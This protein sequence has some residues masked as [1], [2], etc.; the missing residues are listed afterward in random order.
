MP[1]DTITDA[2]TIEHT[3]DILAPA[4]AV[5][6]AWADV[7]RWREWDPDTRSARLAG[8]V[9]AGTRGWLRPRRGLPVRLQVVEA[10][11]PRRL[12]V[13]CPVLG[14]RL[15]FVHELEELAPGRLRVRHRASFHGWLARWLD[16][17]VGEDLR[18]GLP[19]TMAGLKRHVEAA[20]GAP[21]RALPQRP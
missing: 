12:V 8:P 20:G 10:Q 14:S 19:A 5:Y 6:A 13:E 21:A 4:Q 16:R 15:R 11:P 1:R 9:R 2:P 3:I 18:R 17:S 7:A